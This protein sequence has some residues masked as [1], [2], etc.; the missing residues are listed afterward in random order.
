MSAQSQGPSNVDALHAAGLVKDKEGL[1][2]DYHSVFES[3]SDEELGLI[4]LVKARLDAAVP[5]GVSEPGDYEQFVA[6]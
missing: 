5:H 4:L 2:D 6:F 3:L 1:A